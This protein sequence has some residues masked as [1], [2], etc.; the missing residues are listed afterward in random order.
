MTKIKEI[1]SDKS[2]LA[3]P[4]ACAVVIAV[5]I[6]MTGIT[7]YFRLQIIAAG[8]RDALQASVLSV[9]VDNYSEL[10]NGLREGYAGGYELS[11]GDTW[12]ENTDTG[13][14]Y[15]CLDSALGLHYTGTD[16]IKTTN[17]R[18]EYKLYGLNI[19]IINVPFAPDNPDSTNKFSADA[20][21]ILE[22]PVYFAGAELLP[23]KVTLK[24]RAGYMPKL[25]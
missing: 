9:A 20:K 4:L 2:G 11:A 23:L 17:G 21:I 19:D 5:I 6:I 10:Y 14:V 1:L 22:V 25:S 18:T 15:D 3:A 12:A 13:N 8:V 7:E 16:H 24:V